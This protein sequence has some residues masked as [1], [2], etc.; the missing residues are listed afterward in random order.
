MARVSALLASKELNAMT[1]EVTLQKV[2]IDMMF[3]TIFYMILKT[4]T[5]KWR[6]GDL[7]KQMVL[8]KWRAFLLR[9]QLNGE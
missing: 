7:S 3:I 4:F 6:G 5:F 9:K 8:K 1:I 2:L